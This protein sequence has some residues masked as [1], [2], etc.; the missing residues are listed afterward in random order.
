MHG[1]PLGSEKSG[2]KGEPVVPNRI[3]ICQKKKNILL[4]DY[5]CDDLKWSELILG[6]LVFRT[7][8]YTSEQY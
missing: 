2:L 4:G 5:K 8:K 7:K 3:M 6:D 1:I